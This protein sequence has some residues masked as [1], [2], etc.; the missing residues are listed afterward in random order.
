MPLLP[1]PRRR[2]RTPRD[3]TMS[4]VEHLEELRSRLIRSLVAL[5]GGSVVGWVLYDPVLQ[6]LTRPYCDYLA[7]LPADAQPVEG[8]R[9]YFLGAADPLVIKLKIVV[10]IGLFVALPVILWQAWR[11][12]VPGLTQRERRMAIPFVACSVLLFAAGA[13][14]AYV[15]LPRGL[16]FLLGFAGS[17]FA[18]LLTGDRFLSFIM[19]VA[20]AFG[21]AFEFPVVLV[22]LA[23]IGV[24]TSEQLRGAR[25]SAMLFVAVFAAVI[26]PSGDPYT[27]LAMMLPMVAFYEAAIL[28]SR[29]TGK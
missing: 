23:Q 16:N 2:P 27:M 11:F 22:F 1:W 13:A 5:A 19:L 3:G 7:T 9:L 26:T 10:F 17:Q 14:M 29:W 4:L 18:P 28:V 12:V 6:I 25:R 21:L 24:V 8:C 20:L 15:T